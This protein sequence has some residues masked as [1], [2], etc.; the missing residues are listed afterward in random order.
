M[1]DSILCLISALVEACPSIQYAYAANVVL[2]DVRVSGRK[3]FLLYNF[4]FLI[5]GY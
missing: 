4:Y 1:S 3:P 2:R 5:T